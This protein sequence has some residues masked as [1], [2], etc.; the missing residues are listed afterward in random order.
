LALANNFSPIKCTYPVYNAHFYTL[1]KPSADN[2]THSRRTNAKCLSPSNSNW[3]LVGDVGLI[4]PET[5]GKKGN[6]YCLKSN[7]KNKA[8]NTLV[9]QDQL[10]LI[11]NCT[12]VT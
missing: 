4:F 9:A 5:S 1:S 3:E 7:S 2:I 12:R 6:S 11:T 10:R 8:Q